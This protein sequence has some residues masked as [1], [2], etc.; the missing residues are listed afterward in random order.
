MA[1]DQDDRK[2]YLIT[3]RGDY[4]HFQLAPDF[5]ITLKNVLK[6]YQLVN[7]ACRQYNCNRVLAE[8]GASGRK[9]SMSDAF[10]S[11]SQVALSVT[12]LVM[13]ICL[14]GYKTDEVTTFYKTVARNRGARIEFFHNRDD[15]LKWLG[16]QK[17]T[18]KKRTTGKKIQ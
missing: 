18:I 11:G 17:S 9:M 16:I 15:A 3:F 1:D 2:D 13:A 14:K 6:L 7:S 10:E 4:I 5:M 8:G 12:G